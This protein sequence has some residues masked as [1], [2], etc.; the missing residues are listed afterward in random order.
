[1]KALLAKLGGPVTRVE[2][3]RAV[4][5]V[6]VLEDIGTPAAR[7]VLEALARGESEA[8][9]TRQAKAALERL[10]RRPADRP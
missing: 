3:K 4:R 6:A 8:R 9:L 10:G 2:E 5:A 1:V 7:R